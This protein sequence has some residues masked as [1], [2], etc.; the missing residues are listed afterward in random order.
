[1]RNELSHRLLNVKT[2]EEAV[3]ICEEYFG[4][5]LLK[6]DSKDFSKACTSVINAKLQPFSEEQAFGFVTSHFLTGTSPKHYAASSSSETPGSIDITGLTLEEAL[7]R[8]K[9]AYSKPKFA[10]ARDNYI[11]DKLDKSLTRSDFFNAGGK[12]AASMIIN[13][14]LTDPRFEGRFVP[15]LELENIV[16]EL[17]IDIS[18]KV[19]SKSTE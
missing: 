14:V 4:K 16:R 7:E 12:I 11:S 9:E 10:E 18:E 3:I 19:Q 5:P 17:G 13:T 2:Q 6:W 8:V 1:M 15:K